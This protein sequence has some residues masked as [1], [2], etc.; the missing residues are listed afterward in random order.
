MTVFVALPL[1]NLAWQC[2]SGQIFGVTLTLSAAQVGTHFAC[3]IVPL[4]LKTQK[5]KI[6]ERH[7]ASTWNTSER[8]RNQFRAANPWR[9][10]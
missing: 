2:R 5:L 1:P 10:C 6:N 7:T 8:T 3:I 4:N 9:S